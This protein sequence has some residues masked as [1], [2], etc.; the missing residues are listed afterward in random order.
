MEP[1]TQTELVDALLVIIRKRS[2]IQQQTGNSLVV[3]VSLRIYDDRSNF[4]FSCIVAISF[5]PPTSKKLRG[6][7]G[8]SLSVRPLRF[9]YVKN[10]MKF[11][12]EQAWKI[13]GHIVYFL[14][15]LVVAEF[16]TSFDL[17]IVNQRNLVNKISGEPL[18][19]GSWYT[20]WNPD[21][22]KYF[23]KSIFSLLGYQVSCTYYQISFAFLHWNVV[24]KISPKLFELGHWYL[25]YCLD[26]KIN[27]LGI[28]H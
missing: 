5:M 16:C 23:C 12:I 1:A 13:G 20:D 14:V 2:N 19:L 11:Y 26:V 7:I 22:G 10:V 3:R 21:C 6:H 4:Q 8:F 18:E 28:F 24:S 15:G 27:W 17:Y 25:I 9:A